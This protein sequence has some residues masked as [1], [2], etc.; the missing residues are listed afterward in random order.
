MTTKMKITGMTCEHCV[1][2]V[3]KALG[4]VPG[5]EKVEVSL[6]RGEAVV[7]GSADAASLIAAVAGE[8]YQADL[9]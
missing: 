7:G 8:G 5:V 2:A 1:M 9:I 3:S 4:K 6:Q